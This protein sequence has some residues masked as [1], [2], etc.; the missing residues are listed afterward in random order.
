GS[1]SRVRALAEPIHADVLGHRGREVDRECARQRGSAGAQALA[2]E[3]RDPYHSDRDHDQRNHRLDEAE[4]PGLAGA[5]ERR[6][7]LRRSHGHTAPGIC[8]KA[9][10]A[11]LMSWSACWTFARPVASIRTRRAG[12][13]FAPNVSLAPRSSQKRTNVAGPNPTPGAV[14]RKPLGAKLTYPEFAFP[15]K[16]VA[17]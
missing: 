1:G 3:R 14:R 12:E 8:D 4:D 7:Q 15:L 6:A 2:V 10:P 13:K 17:A 11:P 9:P 5:R 16:V